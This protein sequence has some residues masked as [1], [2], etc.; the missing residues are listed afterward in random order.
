V[1]YIF[2]LRAIEGSGF[3]GGWSG[4]GIFFLVG[5]T[6][7]DVMGLYFGFAGFGSS[8]LWTKE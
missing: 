5:D 1:V 2:V 8:S 6:T 4:V 3:L 7:H